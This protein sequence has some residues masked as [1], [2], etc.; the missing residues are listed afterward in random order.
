MPSLSSGVLERLVEEM[1]S[2]QKASNGDRKPGLLQIRSIMPVLA[3]GD[4]WPSKGF[5]LKVS[6][7]THAMYASLPP[8]QD[9]MVLCNKL[10]LGQLIYVEKL[11]AAQPVPV[12]KGI[13]P[14]PGR[15]S[16]VGNPEDLFAIDKVVDFKGASDLLF[17]MEKNGGVEKKARPKFRSL[18]ASKTRPSEKITRVCRSGSGAVVEKVI[19]EV[20][21]GVRK[22]SSRCVEKE[23]DSDSTI[24]SSS[25]AVPAKRRSWIGAE[26]T[27]FPAVR[28]GM[29]PTARRSRSACVSPVPS[30]KSGSDDNSSC[31]IK[32]TISDDLARKLTKNSNSRISVLAKNCEQ[33]L[34][35]P[36]MFNL[37]D[38]SIWSESKIQWSSLPTTL[39]TLGKELLRHRDVTLLAAVEALQEASAAERLLKCLSTYSELQSAEGEEHQLSVNKF[40]DLHDQLAHTRL[41]VQSLTNISPRRADDSNPGSPGSNIREALTLAVD[42]KKNATSWI[43][44]AMASDLPPY[45]STD[46]VSVKATKPADKSSKTRSSK[47]KGILTVKK[48]KN[49]AHFGLASERENSQDWVKGSALSAAADLESSLHD[50]CRRWFLATFESYLDEVKSRT[51]S[52]E[53]DSQV[54]KIM[55]QIKKVC[56]RLDVIVSKEDPEMEAYGRIKEKI[57]GVL[58]KN[59]E[60]TAMVMVQMNA[61]LNIGKQ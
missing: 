16:C 50:E 27:D 26:V 61:I 49:D 28:H 47:P 42:R 8:E 58:L 20:T 21:K 45:F 25:L 33:P 48:Q 44:A 54:A 2:D 32:R 4:L 30:A 10:Q 13:N 36:V 53:S 60:R 35:P 18:S 3:E 24:S 37:P 17:V 56:D 57:Y 7:A 19:C 1:G 40:F 9:D 43:K 11:E 29:K 5:Y 14:V 15:L 51:D 52:M 59:V 46:S 23:T 34:N 38:D 39:V 12:L 41:I 6:D 55:C 22:T 31:K